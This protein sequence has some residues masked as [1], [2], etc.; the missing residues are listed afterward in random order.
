MA[1]QLHWLHYTELGPK[2]L[3][4]VIA[5]DDDEDDDYGGGGDGDDEWG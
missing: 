3:R 1:S 2:W 5:I 4:N